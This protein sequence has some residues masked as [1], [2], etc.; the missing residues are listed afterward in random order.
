MKWTLLKAW[1][2]LL[3]LASFGW[4]Q[5][6]QW[7]QINIAGHNYLYCEG[8]HASGG[9]LPSTCVVGSQ[10]QK[11][12]S[13]AGFYICTATDTWTI[14]PTVAGSVQGA[15]V[16]TT[17]G[18]IPKVG[19]TAGT[20]AESAI[21]D[22]GTRI[23]TLTSRSMAVGV[24][25]PSAAPLGTIGASVIYSPNG[26]LNV[27]AFGASGSVV[28]T[29][30]VGTTTAPATSVTLTSATTYVQGQGIT[31][32]GAGTTGGL[33]IGTI[34]NVVGAVATITPATS[35]TVS[36]GAAVKHDDTAGIQATIAALPTNGGG[37]YLPPGMY[38]ITTPILVHRSNVELVGAGI[39]ASVIY[40]A[41]TGVGI[42]L[43]ALSAATVYNDV[44]RDLAVW[45]TAASSHGIYAYA[46]HGSRVE[47]V[48]VWGNGGNGIDLVNTFNFIVDKCFVTQNVGAGISEET[49]NNGNV[50]RD[51]YIAANGLGATAVGSSNL[52]VVGNTLEAQPVGFSSVSANGLTI[53]GNY[54][55]GHSNYALEVGSGAYMRGGSIRNNY[56]YSN[57][58]AVSGYQGIYGVTVSG[59]YFQS[60]T[61]DINFHSYA[62][63]VGNVI[64]PNSY[65][66]TPVIS[67]MPVG[68]VVIG[69][70][71][72]MSVTA[73]GTVPVTATTSTF[74]G[75]GCLVK[76]SAAGTVGCGVP[77]DI[78]TALKVPE[79]LTVKGSPAV[80]SF[81][82][83]VS[84]SGT[85]VTFS[86]AADAILAG[87]DATTPI[88][89]TTIVAAGLTRYITSWTNSTTAVVDT[90][91]SPV[92]STTAI[93]STQFPIA[94]QKNSAGTVT[95]ATLANGNVGIGTT[96]PNA[97]LQ[98]GAA[99]GD[100]T[101]TNGN[102][103]N[104]YGAYQADNVPLV[105][106][107]TTDAAAADKGGSIGFSGES[108]QGISPYLFSEIKGAKDVAGTYA[109]YL[110]F[111]TTAT[112][113][114]INERM[115]ITSGGNVGIGTT[116]PTSKLT[117]AGAISNGVTTA[118]NS[119]NRGHITLVAGTGSYT[120]TQ[121]PGVAG[122]WTTAPVCLIQDDT[123]LANLATSTKT[124][125]NTAL[126]ITGSVG[127][128]DV[129]SYICWPGN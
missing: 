1:V 6:Q 39:G 103:A 86:S 67:G 101:S 82:G 46:T 18:A 40:N 121:G 125:T 57:L 126:T 8:W 20:L 90:A 102:V 4:G 113:S 98:V 78:G 116:S 80:T 69:I 17:P 5:C 107:S 122:I 34:S 37:V 64:G 77:V 83:T 79:T 22:D 59:N 72:S 74:T 13:G 41:G 99:T 85:T 28:A 87:Y 50:I 100:G 112:N 109:G 110:S 43:N 15:S 55:E 106:I 76:D 128:T 96:S 23:V 129:Y 75:S 71:G 9:T 26:A 127:T 14:A 65:S 94:L 88:V 44:V 48:S 52:V 104:L 29:T 21:S 63:S 124:V 3:A 32:A 25:L 51:S 89:G 115:R 12:G 38:R 111:F 73:G 119:D 58:T 123:T 68:N 56:F 24:T 66:T 49:W 36:A 117:V 97:K 2:L 27:M 61:T 92:W 120:F 45:G 108:D 60:N 81:A 33:Y 93:T 118:T 91:P 84:S 54:F 62:G 31:I 10:Y 42:E 95:G 47:N 30:T 53:D 16:L 35:T 11:T 105:N 19:A 70:D 114:A 7:G